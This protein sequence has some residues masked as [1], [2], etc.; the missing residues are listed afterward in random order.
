[1]SS[2]PL[3]G[4]QPLCAKFR[5]HDRRLRRFR[6]ALL[7]F[8]HT[9]GLFENCACGC[10]HSDCPFPAPIGYVNCAPVE[11]ML[12]ALL[13][14]WN[15]DGGRARGSDISG[16]AMR[17]FR[18]ALLE[19]A[20]DFELLACQ[21]VRK[22][23]RHS[24][25]RALPLDELLELIDEEWHGRA[26][27]LQ[28]MASEGEVLNIRKQQKRNLQLVQ[29]FGERLDAF[30]EVVPVFRCCRDTLWYR[31]ARH[32]AIHSLDTWLPRVAEERVTRKFLQMCRAVA[33]DGGWKEPDVS[34]WVLASRDAYA[35]L[36][37]Y[38]IAD[39]PVTEGLYEAF[40][41]S[42][43]LNELLARVYS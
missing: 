15:P 11:E 14:E 35:A 22:P 42:L 32:L 27:C 38:R 12:H 40:Q 24:T 37:V 21:C 33:I 8:G 28:H 3:H 39:P 7:H 18:N 2:I 34:H 10:E 25:A 29:A 13:S 5:E 30:E 1:M 17:P 26:G 16:M 4:P 23:C 36:L 43:P 20:E 6:H 9:W 31:E 19:F 41:R